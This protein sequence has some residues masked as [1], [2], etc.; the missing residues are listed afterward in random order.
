MNQMNPI[1]LEDLQKLMDL[2][3]DVV[4]PLVTYEQACQ[5]TGKSM[6]ALYSKI[7]RSN[8]KPVLNRRMLRYS[9]VMKIKNKEV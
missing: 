1:T 7:S 3:V 9:D 4:N 2:I 8:I 5:I 6:S